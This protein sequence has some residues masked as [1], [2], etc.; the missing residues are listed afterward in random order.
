MKS[1]KYWI[2]IFVLKSVVLSLPQNSNLFSQLCFEVVNS[3][4]ILYRNLTC[5]QQKYLWVHFF[6][7]SNVVDLGLQ[8]RPHEVCYFK[9]CFSMQSLLARYPQ[10]CLIWFILFS[11]LSLFSCTHLCIPLVLFGRGNVYELPTFV[12]TLCWDEVCTHVSWDRC[13]E[14]W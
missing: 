13:S 10:Q 6:G 4:D 5:S 9:S 7:C 3:E 8:T 1:V 11:L 14:K 2:H 12:F